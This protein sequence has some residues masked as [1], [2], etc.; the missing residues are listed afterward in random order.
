MVDAPQYGD[1]LAKQLSYP[2]YTAGKIR[3][4]REAVLHRSHLQSRVRNMLAVVREAF[5]LTDEYKRDQMLANSLFPAVA[6][7]VQD[8]KAAGGITHFL[9]GRGK[10]P[11]MEMFANVER[12][13]ATVKTMETATEGDEVLHAAML[14]ERRSQGRDGVD[15]SPLSS[16]ISLLE[17][18][19]TTWDTDE[20][21]S[22]QKSLAWKHSAITGLLV[23]L[24]APSGTSNDH[25][26]TMVDILSADTNKVNQEWF[27]GMLV[28]PARSI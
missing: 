15:F 24:N 17:Q 2:S 20:D 18:W 14:G 6:E 26:K 21:P 25:K 12:F 7:L 13:S 23:E 22:K 3:D 8:H 16:P 19:Y 5:A 10:R 1:T 28:N 4:A 11:I 27:S 9:I